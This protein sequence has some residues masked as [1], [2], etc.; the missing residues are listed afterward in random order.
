MNLARANG[1]CCKA[2]RFEGVKCD[3]AWQAW[4]S[5]GATPGSNRPCTVRMA[6][7]ATRVSLKVSNVFRAAT[8]P[9]AV[10][11]AI[12]FDFAWQASQCA[13]MRREIPNR[14]PAVP[15]ALAAKMVALQ[16][17]NNLMCIFPL[18]LRHPYTTN[19]RAK[20]RVLDRARSYS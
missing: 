8:R 16:V 7:A 14:V 6:I 4:Q 18:E 15:L 9:L 12:E 11:M 10:P 2:C 3:F 1:D 17:L 5:A 19:L 20:N 13:A